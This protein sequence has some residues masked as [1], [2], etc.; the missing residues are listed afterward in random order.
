MSDR[1]EVI[2]ADYLKQQQ[3]LHERSDYGTA[4]LAFAPFVK[5]LLDITR[6]SSLADYGAGKQNLR[7]RLKQ[8]GRDAFTYL[9]YDPAFPDYGPPRTA[10]LAC[11]IDVLEHIEPEHL[12]AVLDDLAR[13][14]GRLG[15]FTVHTGPAVKLLSDGRNA[16]LIQQPA[17]WWLPKFCQRFEI[18]H[19]Q[20]IPK[21]FC[22]LVAPKADS[23]ALAGLDMIEIRRAAGRARF[24][25]SV[26]LAVRAWRRLQE[27]ASHG[28]PAS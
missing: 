17:S 27:L 20:L 15:F 16:H 3:T 1:A 9:P 13:I 22:V 11:C 2:S 10:E 25:R 26:P 8:L 21:G 14:T 19:L 18:V 12:D 24:K 4:S 23:E 5:S 7:R 28:H 6:F